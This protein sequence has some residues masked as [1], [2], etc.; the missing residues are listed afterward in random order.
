[1]KKSRKVRIPLRKALGLSM[2]SLALPLIIGL[3]FLHNPLIAQIKSGPMLGY[4]GFREVAVWVQTDSA[5]EVQFSYHA[6]G[7]AENLHKKVMFAKAEH[8]NTLTFIAD[9][10]EVGT[11]YQYQLKS[12]NG[13]LLAEGEFSTQEL[14]QYRQ[15]PP[16]FSFLIGSCTYV[17][18]PHYDR[19]GE[20]YGKGLEIFSAM[21]EKE[22]EAMLWLGDNIYLRPADWESRTGIHYRYTHFKSQ[23]ILQEFWKKYHHYALWDDHDYGPNDADRS[24]INKAISLEAFKDF[25]ANP[26][27]GFNSRN[28]CITGSFSYNDVDFFLLDNRSF[29]S[30]NERIS[31]ERTI[32]GDE[33][34]EWLIDALVGSK[35]SFKIVAIGGQ[36]LNP[37]ALYENH[38][39]YAAEREKILN[40]IEQEQI[41]NVV[42]LSGDRHKTELSK[43]E[44]ESGLVI[45]DFT[46]SPLSSS[47]Y[48]S[49]DEGNYLRVEG[50]HF[51]KQN[52]GMLKL[53]GSLKE[54]KL[55]MQTYD[56]KGKLVWSHE[57][58]V[59]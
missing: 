36:F 39:T 34:I 49:F 44:G 52:F 4:K 3:G 35:A 28:D 26:N 25:W 33:Q 22:A 50:T 20:P 30:P 9:E 2:L 32:L 51:H 43:W 42:F 37:A 58:K 55:I 12:D 24:F 48:N 53:E 59:K 56:Q 5:I 6:V 57:I 40:L 1:M 47:S 41:E 16:D 7:Q 21:L 54:R 45:Y 27:Y 13:N 31:G 10:L 46:S 38:S 14:W 8:A 15:D 18:D 23:A 11:D 17:N 19:P 29:R